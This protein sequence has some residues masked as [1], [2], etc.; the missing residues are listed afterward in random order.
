MARRNRTHP[1]ASGE[2]RARQ[3]RAEGYAARSVYKLKEIDRRTGLLSRHGRVLD[4]GAAPG[5]WSA[6]AAERIGLA[7]K[8]VAVDLAP[9]RQALPPCCTAL[10]HDAFDADLLSLGPL[11]RILPLDVVLSDMAPNT[12]GDKRTDQIRSHELFLRALEV[13][14]GALRPGGHFVG[15]LF[16]SGQFDEARRAVRLHFEAART[17]RPRA[18]RSVSYEVYLVGLGRLDQVADASR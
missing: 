14:V 6:Y 1:Y 18:V 3:A 16:M 17:I 7:G 15:K 8:L 2:H 12:T 5:S 10:E 13:A 4:L 9:L 11:A